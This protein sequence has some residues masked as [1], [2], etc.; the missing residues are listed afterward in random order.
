MPLGRKVT[1]RG[2]YNPK[3][4]RLGL[5]RFKKSSFLRYLNDVCSYGLGIVLCIRVDREQCKTLPILMA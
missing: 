3:R 4:E 2:Y 5:V 1:V